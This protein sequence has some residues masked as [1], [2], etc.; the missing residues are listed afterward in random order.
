MSAAISVAAFCFSTTI[1][2]KLPLLKRGKY[3]I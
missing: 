2:P 1:S 3:L